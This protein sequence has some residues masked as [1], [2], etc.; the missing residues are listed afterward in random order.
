MTK[1]SR[2]PLL[3]IFALSSQVWSFELVFLN[4]GQG[5][6][7]LI[8]GDEGKAVLID[9][10][11]T[12]G[13]DS[14]FGQLL[15]LE[16]GT[17]SISSTIATHFDRDHIGY[18][19][20][21]I[22]SFNPQVVYDHGG[23]HDTATYD[24]YVAAAGVN[25][26]TIEPGQVIE[27]DGKTRLTCI[28]VDGRLSNG[29]DIAVEGE[30][31]RSVGMLVEYDDFS[32][33]I[34]G[35]LGGGG[36]GSVD[37]ESHVAPIVGDLEI[38]RINHHGSDTS[39]NQ[40]FLETLAPELAV[41]SVGGSNTFGHPTQEVL[42]RIGSLE[43]IQ[44]ILQTTAGNAGTHDLVR[45]A[46]GHIRMRIQDGGGL[47][48]LRVS[49][50][51]SG[52]EAFDLLLGPITPEMDFDLNG[53]GRQDVID[54]A[55]LL[56][57]EAN[58]DLF[59]FSRNWYQG[60][61][62]PPTATPTPSSLTTPT[63]TPSA[64]STSGEGTIAPTTTL[65]PTSLPSPSVTNTNSPTITPSNTSSPTLTPTR[66][67]TPSNTPTFTPSFTRTSTPT[68]TRTPTPTAP[69]IPN[70]DLYSC[71]PNPSGPDDGNEKITIINRD[72][73]NVDLSGWRIRDLANHS[74]T[75]SGSIAP[76]QQRT[77]TPSSAW[78]NNTG[79]DT[80][81]IENQDGVVVDTKSYSGTIAD[82]QVVFF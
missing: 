81:R 14:A 37:L 33:F 23:T 56:A 39:S 34:S 64:T 11:G 71:V 32:C 5:D 16:L 80:L 40:T 74:V 28:V 62:M 50:S 46:D 44:A 18:L 21:V 24:Q 43:S 51:S 47:R 15:F 30:N 69:R 48:H 4:V 52:F 73:V 10:G 79:G 27:L 77:F 22:R 45:T 42:D 68:N 67:F 26:Q 65:T 1:A 57:S 54:L 55:T 17:F 61:V 2:L 8:K 75:L 60:E 19:D 41:I 35:D 36:L 25:R 58:P 78:L 66:T 20:E 59:A 29:V 13:T 70:I 7:T 3:L 82:D 9:A 38:L 6:S 72:S 12:V 49:S 31:D 76:N 53:D 63:E